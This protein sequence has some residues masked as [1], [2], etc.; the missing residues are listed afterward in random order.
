MC[1]RF[2]QFYT[3]AEAFD[4]WLSGTAGPDTLQPAAKSALREWVV[5]A[6]VNRTGVG[7]DDPDI[8]RA[9]A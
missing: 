9:V 2:T 7:D 3:R 4:A 1:G 5:D 8:V 6:R